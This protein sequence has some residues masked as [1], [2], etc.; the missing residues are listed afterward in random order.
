MAH[1]GNVAL[2]AAAAVIALGGAVVL[3][4]LGVEPVPTIFYLLAWYPTL[5]L[6]DALVAMRGGPSLWDHPRETAARLW[7]SVVIWCVFGAINFGLRDWYY[8]FAPAR[9]WQ[10]GPGVSTSV[11]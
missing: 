10:R 9:Q 11:A 7:W 2:V 6:L 3:R 5:L 4:G 1:K 8:V